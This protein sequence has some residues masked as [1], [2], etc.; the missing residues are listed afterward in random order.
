MAGALPGVRRLVDVRRGAAAPAHRT[1]AGRA[2]RRRPDASRQ[3]ERTRWTGR[4]PAS[5][6]STGSWAAASWRARCVAR[7][8]AGHRQ[9]D[10]PVAARRTP[11]GAGGRRPLRQRGGV[12][13]PAAD[14]RRAP[15]GDFAGDLPRRRDAPGGDARRGLR[16]GRRGDPGGLDPGPR[17]GRARVAAG[18]DRPGEPLRRP[19]GRWRRRAARR[20]SSSDTS[21]RKARSPGPRRSSTSSTRCSRSTA[22]ARASRAGDEEPVRPVRELALFEMRERGLVAVPDPSQVLLGRRRRAA[23]ARRFCRRR[24]LASAAGRGPGPR[25]RRTSRR[26]GAWRS[27][28]TQPGGAPGRGPGALRRPRAGVAR[29]VPQRRGRLSRAGAGRRPRSRRGLSRPASAGARCRP[30][31]STSARSGCW[32]RS[33]RWRTRRLRSRRPSRSA[34]GP[35]SFRRATRGGGGVPG[36]L[37]RPAAERRGAARED[38]SVRPGGRRGSGAGRKSSALRNARTPPTAIPTSLK[39]SRISQTNG[40]ATSA[41]RATGQHRMKRMTQRRNFTIGGLRR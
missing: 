28:S 20:C 34:F 23:R 17:A 30:T 8:R 37:R 7:R 6:S 24:R 19:L 1:R 9:V 32:A 10:A 16:R 22:S 11:G 36:P 26:R 41:I 3:V 13:A 40:K 5:P 38:L 21:P 33:A 14:A 4:R 27:A 12:S 15:R 31:R 25:S 18:L 2:S 35:R 39:G 29:R